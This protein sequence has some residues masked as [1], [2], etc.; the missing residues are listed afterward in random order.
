MPKL[1]AKFGK[2]IVVTNQQCIGKGIITEKDL[3]IVHHKMQHEIECVG[4]RIDAIFFAPE[5]EH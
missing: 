3:Q 2:I 5:L 4:G 1:A